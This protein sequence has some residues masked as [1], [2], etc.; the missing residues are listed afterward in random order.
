MGALFGLVPLSAFG[1]IGDHT[2]PE[3]RAAVM[4]YVFCFRDAGIA[5][6]IQVRGLIATFDT[7]LLAFAAVS[8]VCAAVAGWAG[9]GRA[10]APVEPR[11]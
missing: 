10:R 2:T 3:D 5:G 6:A 4:G 1:W 8:L 9:F 7:A 11:A